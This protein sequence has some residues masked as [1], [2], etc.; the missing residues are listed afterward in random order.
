LVKGVQCH[1]TK[2]V[3]GMENLHYEERLKKLGLM[4]LDRSR[5]RSDLLETC[6]IINWYYDLTFDTF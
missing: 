1:A 2:L 3:W 4:C 6:K 5:V